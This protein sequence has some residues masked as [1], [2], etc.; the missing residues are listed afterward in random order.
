LPPFLVRLG[1]FDRSEKSCS[2]SQ[3]LQLI[4][5][6]KRKRDCTPNR[7]DFQKGNFELRKFFENTWLRILTRQFFEITRN[8][9]KAFY[10][11]DSGLARV[12]SA[13]AKVIRC[14][15]KS[16][17]QVGQCLSLKT[18]WGIAGTNEGVG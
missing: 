17:C 16:V 12:Y 6:H 14:I 3:N 18:G 10:L 9:L 8:S 2:A 7:Y 13:R 1:K 4:R 15:E 5:E 11:R